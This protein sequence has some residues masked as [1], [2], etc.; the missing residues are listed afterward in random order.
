MYI[1]NKNIHITITNGI[2]QMKLNYPNSAFINSIIKTKIIPGSS[3]TD[4]YI[5]INF[6]AFSVKTLQQY[7]KDN[8]LSLNTIFLFTNFLLLQ[9]NYLINVE[10]S[11]ILGYSIENIL[12]INDN[13]FIFIGLDLIKEIKNNN[14]ILISSPIY[15]NDFFFSPELKN[16]NQL[17]FFT[18]Y[19][20]SYF[21]LGCLILQLIIGNDEFYKDFIEKNHNPISFLDNHFLKNTKFYFFLSRCMEEKCENRKILFI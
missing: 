6:K 9:L 10:N 11:T 3:T 17:P 5:S 21:S 18:S 7:L 2:C 16:I 19:K 4:E 14:E 13:K 1:N 12:V 8:K 20:C 15:N